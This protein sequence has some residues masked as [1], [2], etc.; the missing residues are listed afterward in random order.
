[1]EGQSAVPA[2]S[3]AHFPPERMAALS[4]GVFAIVLTLLV[5][6]LRLPEVDESILTLMADD[7][8]VFAAW[9]ISFVLLGRFW[10]VHH[11][12]TA[13]LR[14]CSTTTLTLNLAVLA[15]VSLV[16]F[17]SDVI[18]TE[19]I[20]E[21][22][23]TVVFAINVGLL[24]LSIGLLGRHAVREPHLRHPDRSVAAL[25]LYQ[26][27]H[28]YVLPLAAAGAAALAFVVPVAA[29]GVLF[30]E[31]LLFVAGGLGR[32]AERDLAATRNTAHRGGTA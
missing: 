4:D 15:T 24:S 8:R 29:V 2:P 21:P 16:P 30:A 31:F 23:S 11:A 12:V 14:R 26:L 17:S 22:W 32:W 6:E 28:L 13:T 5:L 18:G 19:R 3:D 10:L 20:S 1:M 25:G 7:W 27:H 9:L